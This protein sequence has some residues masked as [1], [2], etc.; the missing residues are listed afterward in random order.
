MR[1]RLSRAVG[2]EIR[3]HGAHG[4]PHEVCGALLGREIAADGGGDRALR[5][6]TAVLPLENRRD[7]SPRN[8]FSVTPEDVLRAERAAAA[9]SLELLGW[10]HSHPDHPARPSEF[11]RE[12]AWPW[13]SYVILSVAQREPG[14]MTSWRLA[15]DRSGYAAERI[16][17][18]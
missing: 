3:T 16:E 11:D 12:H 15:D 4:Y 10:Y 2:E 5:E 8:R 13:Y 7:D 1:L 6:V 14:E 18:A 9:S 17:V